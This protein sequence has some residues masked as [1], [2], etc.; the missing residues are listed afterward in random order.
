MAK[1]RKGP[2]DGPFKLEPPKVCR[3]CGGSVRLVRNDAVYGS[4]RGRWPYLYW[5][6]ACGARVGVHP[7]TEL[8][9]GT[10][11]DGAL[12]RARRLAHLALDGLWMGRMTTRSRA[13]RLLSRKLGVPA[14]ECHIGM[15][16]AAMCERV[17][18]ASKEIASELERAAYG[19][20]RRH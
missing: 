14:D 13:Y 10:L 11:A 4:L 17:V 3:Y 16:E 7:R 6:Q 12:Q 8:P 1:Q 2:P 18:A 9:L 20:Q 19:A 5:C 15:F